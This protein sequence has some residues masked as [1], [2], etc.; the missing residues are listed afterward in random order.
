DLDNTLWGG[1]IGE[2]GISGIRLAADYPG[3]AFQEV[4]RALLDIHHRGVLLAI[5][6]K[7]NQAEALEALNTHSG[8]LLKPSHFA[9]MRINWNE[10]AQNLREIC[11]ELS[12]GVD[13]L[14]F[15]DDNP[16]EREQVRSQLP[17]VHVI[18]LTNDP[19]TF[20]G[21][22]RGCPLFERLTL[23]T[24]DRQRGN[25]YQAQQERQQLEQKIESRE[26]FY[27][28][29]LQ[30]AEIAPLTKAT[31]PRIA[32]LTN[33]TNQFN[34]TTKRYTEQQISEM[35]S[36]PEWNCFSI[37]VRDRFGDNGLV[38]VAITRLEGKAVEIDTMLL[39]C[40]V[41][42]RTVETA[43]LSFLAQHAQQRGAEKLQGWF[44]PTKKNAPA[45]EFYSAHGFEMIKQN[46]Q[47]TL[48]SMDLKQKSVCCPEW[49]R[50]HV[51]NG[52]KSNGTSGD[53]Q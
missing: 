11:S 49:I 32:Q 45:S 7:N 53:R 2:D 28:S 4:Q 37:Q 30:E 9:A 43:F 21:A 20:A 42:G 39:S 40:R 17:E 3:A 29:L 46:G 19:M 51:S 34:L 38:G 31:L 18:E 33:K 52:D 41:I 6:S 1:V 48:W 50:L 13:S 44:L 15:L 22:I 8:M 10:K 27:R 12:V 47:G 26:D 16:I 14:A 25:F 35:V 5:C 24:E 23:S 36:S